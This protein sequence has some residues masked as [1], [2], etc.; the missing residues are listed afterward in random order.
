MKQAVMK[1]FRQTLCILA[2]I[3]CFNQPASATGET[4]YFDC[5]VF[6]YGFD[7]AV[8]NITAS[9]SA[10]Q[11]QAGRHPNPGGGRQR[12]YLGDSKLWRDR[13]FHLLPGNRPL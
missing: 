8:E 5:T 2:L 4:N 1:Y 3:L 6:L 13:R 12:R 7:S 11:I 9:S 10:I